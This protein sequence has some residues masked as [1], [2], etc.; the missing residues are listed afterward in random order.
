MNWGLPKNM[1]ARHTPPE[2][3]SG[4]VQFPKET[5]FTQLFFGI[6]GTQNRKDQNVL[7]G[8]F[9]VIAILRFS[10]LFLLHSDIT[11]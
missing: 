4:S 3:L 2:G 7:P 11:A 8:T 5:T 1:V 10:L 9:S 6:S